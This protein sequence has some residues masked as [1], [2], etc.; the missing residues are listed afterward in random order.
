MGPGLR[1]L[2]LVALGGAGCVV[3]L[4]SPPLR[5]TALVG[6]GGGRLRPSAGYPATQR[7]AMPLAGLRVAFH[8]SALPRRWFHRRADVGV[9]YLLER[10]LG[11]GLEPYLHGIFLEGSGWLRTDRVGG[12]W[13]RRLGVV[14]QADLLLA[15]VEPEQPAVGVGVGAG[16]TVEYAIHAEG[17]FSTTDNTSSRPTASA[18]VAA[19]EF[20]L[21]FSLLG[22]WR[23]VGDQSYW[24]ATFQ[25]GF[26]LPALL[27]LLVTS[28][29]R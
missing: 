7:A 11:D 21:T 14:G 20:G 4:A 25:L 13:V 19:G 18:G 27:G 16:L 12:R 29:T 5:A 23:Q 2:L 24:T 17:A 3:P 8:P 1:G 26:R 6:V 28:P 22:A 10:F 9:G 15:A